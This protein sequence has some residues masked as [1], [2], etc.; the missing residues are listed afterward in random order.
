M[1]GFHLFLTSKRNSKLRRTGG[2]LVKK[3]TQSLPSGYFSK[4]FFNP[5]LVPYHGL[6]LWSILSERRS[7][8]VTRN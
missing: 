3:A 2:P 5:D 6:E 1:V 4:P 8:A 7:L